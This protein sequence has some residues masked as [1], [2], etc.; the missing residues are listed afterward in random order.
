MKKFLYE[1]SETIITLQSFEDLEKNSKSLQLTKVPKK[2]RHEKIKVHLLLDSC[3]FRMKGKSSISRKDR[4]WSWK[5]NS[6]ARR[7]KLCK[8]VNG[9]FNVFLDHIPQKIF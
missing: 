7:T 6:P 3:D 5:C 4:Y 8:T 2:N 9:K 1:W